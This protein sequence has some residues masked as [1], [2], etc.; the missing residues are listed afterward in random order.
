MAAEKLED[1]DIEPA[2]K[3]IEAVLQNCRGR[4]DQWLEPYLRISIERLRKTRKNYLKDLLVNVIANGLYYN[5]PMCLTILQH[6]G[7]TSE[8][9]Q[10]WFQMLY[11]VKKSGKPLHFVR[12]HDKKVCILGLA[13]LL[14][15]PT[16]AMPPELQAGLDQ[17]FKALLKLLVAYKEQRAEAAKVEEVEDDDEEEWDGTADDG[18]WDKEIDDDEDEGDES[19]EKL[20]KL[21][22]Q[23]KA[24]SHAD[25]SDSDFE[26]YADDEEFQAPIDNV[27][28]FIF[29]SDAMK[30]MSISD[31]ARFQALSGSLDFQQQAWAHGL[32][33][34]AEERR[35]E[36]EKEAMEKA[37]AAG[38]GVALQ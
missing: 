21:A 2:P 32:A 16:A 15:V 22:A 12:E 25:D 19:T 20:Q 3:L 29:F 26:D 6:L 24:F 18:E 1:S 11:E 10:S 27:D 31:P 14:V 13:S 37:V 35:K 30:A 17:V 23:A 33:Q 34:H 38:A 8:I 4:V 5:A 28:A 7:V 36:I 9:F